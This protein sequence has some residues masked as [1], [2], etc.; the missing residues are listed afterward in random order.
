LPNG[1]YLHS[2]PH[3]QTHTHEQHPNQEPHTYPELPAFDPREI[4]TEFL[5]RSQ[6]TYG[7][8]ERYVESYDNPM[9]I[10][11]TITS[12]TNP[13]PILSRWDTTV[14]NWFINQ[15]TEESNDR[16]VVNSVRDV[17]YP[18]NGSTGPNPSTEEWSCRSVRPLFRPEYFI[19]SEPELGLP[20]FEDLAN[21]PPPCSSCP[22]TIE[23]KIAENT[24]YEEEYNP[25]FAG[26]GVT[27]AA[28]LVVPPPP[29]PP[30]P[31]PSPPVPV[32]GC[33]DP[34]ANNYNPLA[35]V[36]TTTVCT[37]D[38]VVN[39]NYNQYTPGTSITNKSG[40]DMLNDITAKSQ[41]DPD[42][43][44]QAPDGYLVVS[45]QEWAGA[46][47]DGTPIPTNLSKEQTCAL[48]RP[49][50]NEFAVLG[51]KQHFDNIQPFADNQ[52]P[53]V[54]EIDNWN[55]E[56]IRHIR[57]LFGNTNPAYP[58]ARLFLEARWAAERANTTSWDAQYPL[59]CA[60]GSTVGGPCG[61]CWAN[62]TRFDT[63]N[64][65]CGAAFWPNN[66]GLASDRPYDGDG[67]VNNPT[68]ERVA[69]IAGAPYNNDFVKYPELGSS[70][71]H[72]NY[73]GGHTYAT[74]PFRAGNAEGIAGTTAEL[75]WSL[76]LVTIIVNWICQEGLTG[77][78]GP[79]IGNR[80]MF[81]FSWWDD[82][83]NVEFRGKSRG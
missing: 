38:P 40:A 45:P 12:Y 47:W 37:Y 57:A 74:W 72:P 42:V 26:T 55:M 62:G 31:P 46:H 13:L 10:E 48:I 80:R 6:G 69:A 73:T 56:V 41:A 2:H 18:P 4:P 9:G 39:N 83:T 71:I 68:P 61:P 44:S 32:E 53:T 78:A 3:N 34:A 58:D 20:T 29:P 67:D 11:D 49:T 70:P 54:A 25:E 27:P 50:A 79:Y 15:P 30:P 77:H 36:Q 66:V 35:T 81:G 23:Q 60:G 82:G 59:D 17:L 43:T 51:L 65:H 75:P 22:L 76:K 1:S 14:P 64:G 63:A 52:N 5:S 7:L 24:V 16:E 33:M 8:L 21:N 28:P 19:Q